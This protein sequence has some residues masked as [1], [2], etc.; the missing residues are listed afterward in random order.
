MEHS[1]PFSR[2]KQL[3]KIYYLVLYLLIYAFLGWLL[4]TAYAVYETG[5]FV[6]RGF[7]YGPNCPIYGWGAIILTQFLGK[8]KKE[9]C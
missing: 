7:L 9:N 5:G 2:K 6:K 3:T 1:L 8:Y 4:E